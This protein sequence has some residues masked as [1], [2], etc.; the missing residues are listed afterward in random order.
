M[1]PWHFH[2]SIK[3]FDVFH[4]EGTIIRGNWATLSY[5]VNVSH[6][7][8]RGRWV[9]VESLNVCVNVLCSVRKFVKSTL[10]YVG[11]SSATSCVLKEIGLYG[12]CEKLRI[13]V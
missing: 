8:N 9:A 7:I 6:V 10:T 3:L 4:S 13:C 12:P 5:W 2:L 1:I 11:S